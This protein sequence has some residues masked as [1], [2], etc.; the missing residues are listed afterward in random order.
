MNE[1]DYFNHFAGL[2]LQTN[3]KGNFTKHHTQ[4]M[5]LISCFLIALLENRFYS[6]DHAKIRRLLRW[7]KLW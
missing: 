5:R 4:T 7:R 2:M 3:G 6:G 1:S